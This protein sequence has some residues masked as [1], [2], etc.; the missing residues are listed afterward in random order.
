MFDT[1]DRENR[2]NEEEGDK[3]HTSLDN[4]WGDRTALPTMGGLR[5]A[6]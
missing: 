1:A 4:K 6:I 3:S 5:R 2:N